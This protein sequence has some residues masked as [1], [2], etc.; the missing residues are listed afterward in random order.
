MGQMGSDSPLLTG[1]VVEHR[2]EPDPVQ[3]SHLLARRR[4]D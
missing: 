3:E 1:N 4:I 2:P